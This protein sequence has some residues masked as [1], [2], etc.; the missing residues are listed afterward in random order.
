MRVKLCRFDVCGKHAAAGHP[1]RQRAKQQ[2]QHRK[3]VRLAAVQIS[4]QCV[5]LCYCSAAT[6][7]VLS[8]SIM[9][10]YATAQS[11]ITVLFYGDHNHAE[12]PYSIY[13]EKF[14]LHA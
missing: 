14:T 12:L 7:L 9:P 2:C 4:M 10:G 13:D 11:D 5:W 6:G 3:H 1:A 8:A